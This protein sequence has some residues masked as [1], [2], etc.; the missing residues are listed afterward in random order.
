MADLAYRNERIIEIDGDIIDLA[1][2][3]HIKKSKYNGRT[4]Y[5]QYGIYMIGNHYINITNKD[6]GDFIISCLKIYHNGWVG[7]PE[8]PGV[9][10]GEKP[11]KI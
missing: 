4:N 9:P 2:I 5:F 11:P 10:P 6:H 3:I 7:E 8:L 1:N